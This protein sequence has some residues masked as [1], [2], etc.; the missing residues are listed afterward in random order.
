MKKLIISCLFIAGPALAQQPPT[1]LNNS[2]FENQAIKNGT[3]LAKEIAESELAYEKYRQDMIQQGI[4]PKP[5][6]M[7]NMLKKMDK[8]YVDAQEN[9]RLKN[10]Y[11]QNK[12][13]GAQ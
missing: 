6:Y 7:T 5:D 2:V 12:L 8:V 4:E 10:I 11:F 3:P 9:E 13:K 1:M